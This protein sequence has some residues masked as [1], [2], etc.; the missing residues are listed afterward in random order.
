MSIKSLLLRALEGACFL[1]RRALPGRLL[2]KQNDAQYM[3]H[4]NRRCKWPVYAILGLPAAAAATRMR[5]THTT[6]PLRQLTHPLPT[7]I[8][9]SHR[10]LQ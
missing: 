5:I 6:S 9:F 4:R 3:Q 1:F 2:H 8:T 7:H 10:Q